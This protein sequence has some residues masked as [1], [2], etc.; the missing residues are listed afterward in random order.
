M[1]QARFGTVDDVRVVIGPNQGDTTDTT[2]VGIA[3]YGVSEMTIRDSYFQ[4]ARAIYA[5]RS[6]TVGARL[7]LDHV[8]FENVQLYSLYDPPLYP[9]IESKVALTQVKFRGQQPW[10]GGAGAFRMDGYAASHLTFENIRWENGSLTD[11]NVDTFYIVGPDEGDVISTNYNIVMF[12]DCRI[13]TL[14]DYAAIYARYLTFLTL[15]NVMTSPSAGIANILDVDG[16]CFHAQLLNC[17]QYQSTGPTIGSDMVEVLA[18]GGEYGNAGSPT[19]QWYC[20]TKA[21]TGGSTGKPQVTLMGSKF[22]ANEGI[23][24]QND[25]LVIWNTGYEDLRFVR[26][27]VDIIDPVS[28][29]NYGHAV[30]T[31]ITDQDGYGDADTY[32]VRIIGTPV[33][34]N[35]TFQ[36]D[37]TLANDA[38][39]I[40]MGGGGGVLTFKSNVRAVTATRGIIA[41]IRL[42]R[43]DFATAPAL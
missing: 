5:P 2:S 38:V 19:T 18:I 12:R 7:F 13:G 43:Y 35:I 33:E 41:F 24:E 26:I 1:W 11:A 20:S 30:Y 37:S 29:D 36:T 39:G 6:D 28:A 17:N 40:Y 23:Y 10:V 16:T 22:W 25:T 14:Q 3:L 4:A 8:T 32:T 9:L 15:D 42:F 31:V 21:W 34:E 27:E